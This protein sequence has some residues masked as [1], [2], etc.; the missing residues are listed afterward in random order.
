MS[1]RSS[2][3]STSSGRSICS[4]DL[5]GSGP[6]SAATR[7]PGREPRPRLRATF[8]RTGGVRHLFAAY[9]L[10]RDKLYGHIKPRKTRTR[11]LEFCTYL[12]TLYTREIRI[13][14][15]IDNFSSHLSTKRDRRVGVWAEASN[16]E[17]GLHPDQ[18]LL[19]QPDRGSV[20]RA[21]LLR[22]R[23][24]RPPNPPGARQHD[25][26]LYHL[27]KPVRRRPPA[28]PHRQPG[29][30]SLIRH[31]VRLCWA[32]PQPKESDRGERSPMSH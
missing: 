32:A 19:A 10:G 16:V 12:R 2:S 3:A 7:E 20:R 23:R 24:H 25:P 30:R 15:V 14:L 17:L 18:Q 27:A 6:R 22:A 8:N 11:F 26:P 4:R 28:T 9:D 31:W 1:H 29:E 5:V 21:A 13:A